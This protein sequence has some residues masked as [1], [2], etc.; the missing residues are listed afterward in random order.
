MNEA[1]DSDVVGLGRSTSK[2]QREPA[3]WSDY[4]S[5]IG[6]GIAVATVFFRGGAIIQQQETT[7]ALLM[8]VNGQVASHQREIDALKGTDALHAF[9][10][11]VLTN[12]VESQARRLEQL[13][14]KR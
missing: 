9:Q 5:L 8:Q 11:V 3:K 2:R 13:E 6:T 7:N 14:R 1:Q 12:A 4:L 10:I